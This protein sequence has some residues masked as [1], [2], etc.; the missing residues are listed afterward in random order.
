MKK[1]SILFLLLCSFS[2]LLAAC[3]TNKANPE[4]AQNNATEKA[5]EQDLLAKVKDEGKLIVGTEGTYAPF[6]FH[7]ESGKLTGFDVEIAQEVANRLGVE[8]EFLETQWDAMFAG[9]DAKRFDMVAN[10]VGIKPER[11]EK[12][13][14]SDPYI[15]SKA[16]LI[17]HESNDIV[18]SFEDIKGL[19]SAQS[20]TTNYADIAKSYGAEIIGVEG[21]IQAIELINSKRADVTINDKISFLDYKRNSPMLKLKL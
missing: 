7:D 12:Y 18:K 21:F 17:T 10:Q 8:A 14:F 13:A 9:L 19:K 15:T 4:T 6:S 16:V 5:G 20:M 1:F 2:I 11:Q 3:G